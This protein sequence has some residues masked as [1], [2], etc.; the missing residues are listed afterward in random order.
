MICCGDPKAKAVFKT[1]KLP[2]ASDI[3]FHYCDTTEIIP[4]FHKFYEV[5]FKELYFSTAAM[6][7]GPTQDKRKIIQ[8]SK[9]LR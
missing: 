8:A 6:K 9:Q 4:L 3:E 7:Q 1:Y 2:N 5:A